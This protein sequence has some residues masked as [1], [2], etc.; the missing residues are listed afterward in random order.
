MLGTHAGFAIWGEQFLLST[1]LGEQIFAPRILI[2]Q[3]FNH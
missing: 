3:L 2:I 1:I